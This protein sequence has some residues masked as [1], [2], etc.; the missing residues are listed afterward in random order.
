M[1]KQLIVVIFSWKITIIYSKVLYLILNV[2]VPIQNFYFKLLNMCKFAHD[3][4]TLT[5]QVLC[6]TIFNS[7][8]SWKPHQTNQIEGKDIL[9]IKQ[10][11]FLIMLLST[12]FLI[13]RLA[14]TKITSH[15]T[16]K[17]QECFLSS[18]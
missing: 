8:R 7:F 3:R 17:S 1:L 10:Y 18:Y 9:P 6:F 11:V 2:Q 16:H 5:I 13:T 4:K 14:E 15:P 12:R